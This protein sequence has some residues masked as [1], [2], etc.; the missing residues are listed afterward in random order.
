MEGYNMYNYKEQ[1]RA[2]V[3]EWIED[4]KEQIEGLDRYDAYEVVYDSCWVD[5]SVT[6]NASGS[7][8]FSG[9]EAREHFYG[10]S[11]SEDYLDQMCDDGFADPMEIGKKLIAS[12]YEWLDVS[13]RCWLLCDAVSDVLDEYYED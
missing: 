1:I 3:K 11:D 2:D 8:T 13:I 7:Y 6:G 5:D 10:D 4:N 12:N 9:Y